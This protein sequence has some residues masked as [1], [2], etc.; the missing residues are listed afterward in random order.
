MTATRALIDR[1]KRQASDMAR[2]FID[3]ARQ[4]DATEME[5]AF[6]EAA[7]GIL[8][9]AE[10]RARCLP[11]EEFERR[12]EAFSAWHRRRDAELSK[13]RAPGA[14]GAAEGRLSEAQQRATAELDHREAEFD[15]WV[16]G[17]AL[18]VWIRATEDL[19]TLGRPSACISSQES[20]ARH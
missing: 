16:D 5:R 12:V 9:K 11:R 17:H 1:L 4:P 15:A 6:G 18:A 13:L 10:T 8:H 7:R 3:A 20:P 2:S 14:K 19:L